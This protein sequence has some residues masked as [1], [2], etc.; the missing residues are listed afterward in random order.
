[1]RALFVVV[2]SLRADALG[3]Y[4]AAA[5]TPTVDVLGAQGARFE[6]V[7][8]S[9]PWTLPSLAAMLTGVWS[10]RLGL[11]KWEQPWPREVPTLFDAFR[12][13]GIE[14]ASFVFDP[15]HLF[16]SCPEAS[17][18]GSSQDTDAMLAWFRERKS[19]DYFAFVHYWWT[20]VPYVRRKL[21][22]ATWNKVNEQILA[23]LSA[24][25]PAVRA[26]N[27]EQ[28]K[29]LYALAVQDFSEQWLPALLEEARADVV[30]LVADHGESWG[31]RLSMDETLDDVFDL[32]GNH[33]HDEVIRV[34]W[35]LHAPGLVAPSVVKGLAR[36][37][38]IMP[39]L[40]EL[41]GLDHPSVHVANGGFARAGRSLVSALASGRI[42]EDALGIC[43]RNE[44]FVDAPALPTDP[45]DVYVELACRDLATKVVADFGSDA[46]R[47]YDLVRDPGELHPRAG[48]ESSPLTRAL[49]AEMRAAAVAP[50][51][52]GDFACMKQRLRDLGYL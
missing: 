6:T 9:A 32:H 27:R 22:L 19:G 33:L 48:S 45:R 1:M 36:S 37:V 12:A 44:D 4:G 49:R 17:V 25:D 42:A 31:E 34:P 3:C 21:P 46:T 15:D 14:T 29:G 30:V 38:D 28:V 40:V 39:T 7:V 20:H 26:A 47:E 50:H 5:A 18:V 43:A 13:K 11:M 24:P 2:D 35:I 16:R 23:L 51:E 8:S 41:L 52:P 10:H